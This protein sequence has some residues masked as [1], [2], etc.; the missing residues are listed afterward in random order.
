MSLQ[1]YLQYGRYSLGTWKQYLLTWRT[2]TGKFEGFGS[3]LLRSGAASPKK[4]ASADDPEVL[5]GSQRPA[6]NDRRLTDEDMGRIFASFLPLLEKYQSVGRLG[7][8]IFK[9]VSPDL[10][11]VELTSITV[12]A[13]RGWDMGS[14]L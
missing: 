4:L 9:T 2:G 14:I 10:S 5:S 1:S 13:V 11:A 12:H 3:R 8:E 6:Q 7:A